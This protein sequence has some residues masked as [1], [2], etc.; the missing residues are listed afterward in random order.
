MKSTELLR[1]TAKIAIA[2]YP[3]VA[4]VLFMICAFRDN[5]PESYYYLGRIYYY[6]LGVEKDYSLAF[7]YLTKAVEN[8]HVEACNLYSDCYYHGNGVEQDIGKYI[9]WLYEYFSRRKKYD[10]V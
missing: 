6:G 9:L 5:D 1:D 7:N 2:T 4:L 3:N 10:F 8:G